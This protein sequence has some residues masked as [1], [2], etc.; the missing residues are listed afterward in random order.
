MQMQILFI[1]VTHLAIKAP[2]EMN[3]THLWANKDDWLIDWLIVYR[4][5]TET[6]ETDTSNKPNMFKCPNCNEDQSAIYKVW[7]RIWTRNYRVTNPASGK[8]EA[9]I[10]GPPDYNTSTLYHAASVS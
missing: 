4:H 5:A 2:S 3:E 7:Q 9:L 8:V 1:V 6:K 10:S